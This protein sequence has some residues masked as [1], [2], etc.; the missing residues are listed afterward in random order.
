VSAPDLRAAIRRT[1]WAADPASTKYALGGPCFRW[2]A[3]RLTLTAAD[4]RRVAEAEI[5][6]DSAA[7]H[8][9]WSI[10]VPASALKQIDATFRDADDV[11]TITFGSSEA[12]FAS[13]RG[14]VVPARLLHGR[15]PDLAAMQPDG[16]KGRT[17]PIDPATFLP[18]LKQVAVVDDSEAGSNAVTL[19]L[20]GGTMRLRS[21]ATSVGVSEAEYPIAWDAADAEVAVNGAWLDTA[22][23]AAG[24]EPFTLDLAT[25]SRFPDRAPDLMIESP[26]F[27]CTL[28]PITP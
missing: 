19:L 23:R 10:V 20:S 22:I 25:V 4:G 16:S 1:I 6:C 12:V 21:A 11:L 8:A 17:A 26:G 24:D 27:R 2:T 9:E 28:V 15:F 7:P 18:V 5:P 14:G 13:T 3:D